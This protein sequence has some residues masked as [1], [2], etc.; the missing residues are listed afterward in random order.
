[1][2]KIGRAAQSF[3]Y[4]GM[5]GIGNGSPDNISLVNAIRALAEGL[6][7]F[8]AIGEFGRQFVQ[9]H[10]WIGNRHRKAGEVPLCCCS[11]AA[12]IMSGSDRKLTSMPGT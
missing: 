11:R 8:S 1:M 5:Y 2:L 4:K 6:D 12:E 10:F 3:V 9:E 7:Q